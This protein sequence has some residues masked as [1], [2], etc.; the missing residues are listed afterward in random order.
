[1]MRD[2]GAGTAAE[3][4]VVIAIAAGAKSA[5]RMLRIGYSFPLD[6]LPF[7]GPNEF[8]CRNKEIQA[9]LYNEHNYNL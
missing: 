9:P 7:L 4:E 1:M 8:K 3:A 2:C 5:K 6:A